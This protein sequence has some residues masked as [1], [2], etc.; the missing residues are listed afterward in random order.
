MLYNAERRPF[1]FLTIR[2]ARMR[3]VSGAYGAEFSL[4]VVS[5]I[6]TLAPPE[7]GGREAGTFK[8]KGKKSCPSNRKEVAAVALGEAHWPEG[9]HS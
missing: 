6:E 4:G 3:W 1:P 2:L 8:V 5:A 7:E 9:W